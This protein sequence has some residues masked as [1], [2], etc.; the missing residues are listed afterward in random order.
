MQLVRDTMLRDLMAGE[1]MLGS[2]EG[3]D[4]ETTHKAEG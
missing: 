3:G 4:R 1:G 2:T